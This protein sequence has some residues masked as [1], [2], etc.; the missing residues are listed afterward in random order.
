M[1]FL[2]GEC[3]AQGKSLVSLTCFMHQTSESCLAFVARKAASLEMSL[4]AYLFCG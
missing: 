2:R 1:G 3:N 4:N